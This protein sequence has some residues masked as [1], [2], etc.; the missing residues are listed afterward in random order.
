MARQRGNKWQGDALIDG[1][2]VR[3]SFDTQADA[4]AFERR[5][6]QGLPDI[7]ATTFK[8]FA[9]EQ[10]AFLWGDTKRPD[11]PEINI[12]VL[13]RY[14]PANHPISSITTAYVVSLIARMK[15]DRLSNATI[16]RKLSTLSKL[17]KHAERLELA[18]K[19]HFDFQKEG[20]G[21][22][23]VIDSATERK[24]VQWFEHM[25]LHTSL[26]VFNF[27]LYTGCRKGEIF[28]LTHSSV[29]DGWLTFHWRMTKTSQ[30]RSIPLVGPAKVAWEHICKEGA[31][32]E[33][34][35]SVISK[36][37]F[38][39]HWDRLKTHLGY[40]DEPDFVPHMLRHTCITRLVKKGVPLPQ[41]MKWAGHTNI[42]TTMRYS[43]LAP[44]DLDIAAKA[45][46]EDA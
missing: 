37:T 30:T 13:L 46:L 25:G 40:D 44:Q 18:K 29:K 27:L 21:R 17:M 15:A 10:F 20:K 1:Q 32:V 23:L 5:A 39:G 11:A 41:V 38:R 14:I 8:A 4:E 24:A 34:P 31:G 12:K 35:F 7:G 9:D 36:D 28:Q 2:R 42:Q 22:E 45:L 3:R 43:Q 26:A 6:E 33:R 16:N 19:P